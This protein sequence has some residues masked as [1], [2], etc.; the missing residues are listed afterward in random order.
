M[1]FDLTHVRLVQGGFSQICQVIEQFIVLLRVLPAHFGLLGHQV[2]QVAH[3]HKWKGRFQ[4][5]GVEEP[6]HV[7]DFHLV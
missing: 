6:Q 1:L 5:L 3:G 7:L 4:I 2:S